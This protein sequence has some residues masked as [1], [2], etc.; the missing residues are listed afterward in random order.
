MLGEIAEH[1]DFAPREGNFLATIQAR[2]EILAA[3]T[4]VI[5]KIIAQAK[6]LLAGLSGNEKV[7]L[8][9]AKDSIAA[10]EAGSARAYVASRDM[11][12]M[13]KLMRITR[14]RDA[15]VMFTGIIGS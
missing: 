10:L 14:V 2:Q 1:L 7:L 8:G 5:D 6:E 13:K 3:K 11:A 12:A 9:L 15:S 4:G